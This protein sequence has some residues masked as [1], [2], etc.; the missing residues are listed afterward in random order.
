MRSA[1]LNSLSLDSMLVFASTRT[2]VRSAMRV[3]SSSL[4]RCSSILAARRSCS[5]LRRS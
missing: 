4:T 1:A 2:W 3:S 5:R